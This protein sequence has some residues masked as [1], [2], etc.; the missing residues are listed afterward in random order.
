MKNSLFLFTMLLIGMDACR[1]QDINFK[2]PVVRAIKQNYNVS[3]TIIHNKTVNNLNNHLYYSKV[4]PAPANAL[5]PLRSDMRYD[6]VLV[7]EI[8]YNTFSPERLNTLAS[9]NLDILIP[10]ET[11]LQGNI[12]EITFIFGNNSSLM[13]TEIEKLETR[14]KKQI[15]FTLNDK[16]FRGWK[17]VNP[18]F[19]VNFK[20]LVDHAPNAVYP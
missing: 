6:K 3:E 18:F 1:A 7:A 10:I 20:K 8:F 16:A 14:L 13:P 2:K 15:K 17:Y 4:S 19:S 9:E 11:D 12:F 5:P